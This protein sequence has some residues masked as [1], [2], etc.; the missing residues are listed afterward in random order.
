[1]AQPNFKRGTIFTEQLAAIHLSK[2]KLFFNKA[3]YAGM[4]ILDVSK[5]RM[6]DI[7][8]NV[9]KNKYGDKVQLQYTDTDSLTQCRHW[10]ST[11]I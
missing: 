2:T 5:T 3:I 9:I 10:T 4:S 11:M 8:Y 7:H 6:Y 1:M